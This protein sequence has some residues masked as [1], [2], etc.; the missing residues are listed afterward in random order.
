VLKSAVRAIPESSQRRTTRKDAQAE[1]RNITS[2]DTQTAYVIDRIRWT[3]P[4]IHAKRRE[5]GRVAAITSASVWTMGKAGTTCPVAGWLAKRK[6]AIERGL[7]ENE[8][9]P[10]LF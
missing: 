8:V 3:T 7:R 5:D 1:G 6:R 4:F 2:F 10:P 9:D